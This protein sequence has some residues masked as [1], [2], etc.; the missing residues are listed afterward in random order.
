MEDGTSEPIELR[1]DIEKR[2]KNSLSGTEF[3]VPLIGVG[4]YKGSKIPTLKGWTKG[5]LENRSIREIL[6]DKKVMGPGSIVDCRMY[7]PLRGKSY[8]RSLSKNPIE[9]DEFLS[10]LKEIGLVIRS[11]TYTKYESENGEVI[12]L[13][14]RCRNRLISALIDARCKRET[15]K[16]VSLVH[17]S[18]S[19]L[20]NTTL[21]VD[22][23]I[24]C[25]KCSVT[26]LF[27]KYIGYVQDNSIDI[28]R[29]CVSIKDY[30][31]DLG[32]E[33][34]YIK[35]LKE[36]LV[37]ASKGTFKIL[38]ARAGA[39]KSTYIVCEM[40]EKDIPCL[41]LVPTVKDAESI[42]GIDLR[43]VRQ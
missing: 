7:S 8:S 20:P 16:F 28:S 1:V 33:R 39:G 31:I 30:R 27:E 18:K 5:A 19:N 41:I 36:F 10:M 21:N 25:W 35:S 26:M 17:G 42:A 23:K 37:E 3:D 24:R 40:L 34:R 43:I 12:I 2:I 4:G 9:R 6:E 22:G 14:E 13:N 11:L 38:K 29:Q 15:I 32:V